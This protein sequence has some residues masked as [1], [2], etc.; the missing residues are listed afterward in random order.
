MSTVNFSVPEDVKEAFNRTFE[1]QNKSAI[2]ADPMREAIDRANR[3]ARARDAF[4]ALTA[5]R[6]LRPSASDED[7]RR[8][9]DAM[10]D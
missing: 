5:R 9:R 6:H 10:R 3:K 4:E 7:I 1:G 8:I 2:V